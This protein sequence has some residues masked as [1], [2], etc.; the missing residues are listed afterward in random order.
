MDFDNS[1]AAYQSMKTLDTSEREQFIG[2]A[3]KEA[4]KLGRKITMSPEWEG[5]KYPLMGDVCFAKFSQN[6]DL[7]DILLGTGQG[8]LVENTTSWHDN[9]W[10]TVIAL[11]AKISPAEPIE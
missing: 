11:N 5:V 4:K 3:G 6:Q 7:K 9:I 2:L 8:E 10:E 1:E